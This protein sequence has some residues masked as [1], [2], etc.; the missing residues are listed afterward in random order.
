MAPTKE[1]LELFLELLTLHG[2]EHY[3]KFYGVYRGQVTRVDDPEKRGRIQ[4]HVPAALQNTAPDVWIDPAFDGAG[5]D[6]GF[7]WPPEVGDSVRV[8][9]ERGDPRKPCLYWGGWYGAPASRNGATEVPSELGYPAGT[10][11]PPKRRGLVTRM[12]HT[13]VFDDTSGSE[14]VR[15]S[16]HLPEAGDT[17]LTD[18][19]ATANRSTGQTAFLEFNKDGVKVQNANGSHV[20]LDVTGRRIYV[21]D[22]NGNKVTLDADGAKIQAVRTIDMLANFVNLVNG[23]DAHAVR[24]EDLMQWLAGHTHNTPMG[25]SS[26]PVVP[27]PA[28]I[29]SKNVRLK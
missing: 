5:T 11:T 21:E 29:L 14:A 19:T 18:G 23:N 15:V 13:L 24:G 16:W 28:K 6:R 7:F 2:L 25:P 3:R 26:P 20:H 17:A 10:N 8:C 4:A 22:E 27:P 9:F 1:N 12:G